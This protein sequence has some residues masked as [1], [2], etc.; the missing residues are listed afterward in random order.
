M[1]DERKHA[2]RTRRF[3]PRNISLDLDPSGQDIVHSENL[4]Y[5]NSLLYPSDP[6]PPEFGR[7][8]WNFEQDVIDSWGNYNGNDRTNAGYT[9]DAPIGSHAKSFSGNGDQVTFGNV[10]SIN[11]DTT[12]SLWVKPQSTSF[13]IPMVHKD[14]SYQFHI[15]GE[16]KFWFGTFG[17]RLL[18]QS[19]SWKSRQWYH[20]AVVWEHGS[21]TATFYRNGKP[22]G[23][24]TGYDSPSGG[25]TL[26]LGYK[27]DGGDWLNGSLDDVRYYNT[28]LSPEQVNSLYKLGSD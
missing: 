22:I 23:S 10:L 27:E 17:S 11:S 1:S 2:F 7:A 19:I 12:I 24:D 3:S 20:C 15:N 13:L 8:R 4:I 5:K 9:T 26:R 28:A 16:G 6:E 21:R 25:G 14:G 18:S